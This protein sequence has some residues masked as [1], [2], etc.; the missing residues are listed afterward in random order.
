MGDANAVW[1]FQATS[2]LITATDS[3]VILS[4]GAKAANIYWKVGS[5]ATLGTTSIFKGNILTLTSVALSTGTNVEERVLARNG[6]VTL[7]TNT[8][9]KPAP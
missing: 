4:G 5:S 8:I 6:T 9:V 2:T 3:Q 7:G 1:I